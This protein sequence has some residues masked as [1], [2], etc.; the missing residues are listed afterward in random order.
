MIKTFADKD[1]ETVYKDQRTRRFPGPLHRAARRKLLM[2]DAAS[3][4]EDLRTPPGNHFEVL[5][6]RTGTDSIRVNEQWRITFSWDAGAQNV[7][8]EDYH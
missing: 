2:L 7:K 3:A 8:I 4:P 1:T 6:G 5:H